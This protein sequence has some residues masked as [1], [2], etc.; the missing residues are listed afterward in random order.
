MGQRPSTAQNRNINPIYW[1]KGDGWIITGP[2]LETAQAE[3][4]RKK[5]RTPLLEYSLTDRTNPKSGLR[6]TIEGNADR[7]A[8]EYRYYWLFKNGGAHLFTIEQ[9]VAHHWHIQ[10]PYGLPLSVFPQLEEYD[11]PK[12]YWCAA[13]PGK[14][15]PMNSEEE[16]LTH[17]MITH[18]MTLVQARD[19]I[20]FAQL[21]PK[22][23]GPRLAIRKKV[24]A[25]EAQ[26]EERDRVPGPT[27]KR[28]VVCECG[29]PFS[30]GL[31]KYRHQKKGECPSA[32][33]PATEGT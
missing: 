2:G 28:I 14:S 6:E 10:P 23:R 33:V 15:N 7:L 11:V 19:L 12:P 31:E 21:A 25:I 4:W 9:I 26:A 16:L 30:N 27:P 22:D 13:C 1:Q 5:G 18:R 20:P 8:T 17:A 24:K 29:A 32:S 3:R